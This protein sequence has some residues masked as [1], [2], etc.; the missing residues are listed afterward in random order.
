MAKK[1]ILA[2]RVFAAVLGMITALTISVPVMASSEPGTAADTGAEAFAI[3]IVPG[4]NTLTPKGPAAD[5][6]MSELEKRFSA[7]AIFTG[8]VS[9]TDG[10]NDAA[11]ELTGIGMLSNVK[12]G[13]GIKGITDGD[14]STV[15]ELLKELMES[16]KSL[17]DLGA[18]VGDGIAEKYGDNIDGDTALGTLFAFALTRSDYVSDDGG[19]KENDQLEDQGMS[20]WDTAAVVSEVISDISSAQSGLVLAQTIVEIAAAKDGDGNYIYLADV[21]TARS[22]WNGNKIYNSKN[23]GVWEIG[24]EKAGYYLITDTYSGTAADNIKYDEISDNMLGVFG[25]RIIKLKSNAAALEKWIVTSEGQVKGDSLGIGDKVTFR[26]EGTLPDNF[27]NYTEFEYIFHDT[28]SGGLTYD[29]DS[30]LVYAVAPEDTEKTDEGFNG[31]IYLINAPDNGPYTITASSADNCDLEIGFTDLKNITAANAVKVSAIGDGA[32][33]GAPVDDGFTVTNEWTIAVQYT[34]TVNG[35]AS[36]VDPDENDGRNSNTAYL[37][38]SNN[39]NDQGTGSTGRTVNSTAYVY[40]YGLELDKIIG[41]I[42]DHTS[43]PEAGFALT[44][45]DP[46]TDEVRYAVFVLDTYEDRDGN[47]VNEYTAVG[48]ISGSIAEDLGKSGADGWKSRFK[49]TDLAGGYSGLTSGLGTDHYLAVRTVDTDNGERL[50]I[51]GLDADTEYTLTEVSA[52]DGYNTMY[53]IEFKITET[54]SEGAL[55]ALRAEL[56]GLRKDRTDVKINKGD[57]DDISAGYIRIELANVPAGFLPGTGG[58]GRTLFYIGGGLLLA[59]AA[60]IL[61]VKNT[62]KDGKSDNRS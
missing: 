34:A 38:Y 5:H 18:S 22:S 33:K 27:A 3:T 1:R 36:V 13:D 6:D 61:I 23:Q 19:L 56:V 59:A 32:D 40:V 60:V 21:P 46:V 53:P 35:S 11:E 44:R 39:V 16:D 9:D 41:T 48:W 57:R 51:K 30:V 15:R 20:I 45:T 29:A 12:W 47:T 37:E 4:R 7:Y 31:E 17:S 8:G 24:L 10:G 26:L 28:L 50:L 14:D 43:L 25:S 2:S 54:I 62:K 42:M 55:T 49:D 52:P 58:M